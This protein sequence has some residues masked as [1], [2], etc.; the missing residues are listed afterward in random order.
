MRVT[1]IVLGLGLALASLAAYSQAWEK[2]IAPGLTYRMEVDLATPRIVHA[3][4]F[5]LGAPALKL[6]SELADGTV[7]SDNTTKGRETVTEMVTRT[8]ALAGVNGDFFPFT[9]DPLG[10]MVR[11]GQLI[12][13]PGVPPRAVFGWG[14]KDVAQGMV[15]FKGSIE[16]NGTKLEIDG[17]NEECPLNKL[18]LNTEVA[19]LAMAK[20]PCLHAIVKMDS[21]DWKPNGTYTGT[22]QSVYKDTT[23]LPIQPGNAVITAAGTKMAL[24]ETLVPGQKITIQFQTTGFDWS[25]IDQTMGGA[26]FLLR[27][28]Q[29][30]ID[31]KQQNRNDAFTLKRHP[32]TAM[33]KT[34]DG[35]I[36]LVVVDGR[37]KI[38]DGA[39]LEEMAKVMLKLG[40][41]D[42]VNLDGGGSSALNILGLTLNRPSDGKER[43]VANGALIFGPKPIA[44]IAPLKLKLPEKLVVGT[45]VTFYVVDNEG[46]P[47]PNAEVLWSSLGDAWID[48]GG[49]ARPIQRGKMDVA[50]MV[51]GQ[52]LRATLDVVDPAPPKAVKPSKGYSNKKP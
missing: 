15:D 24:I 3:L 26:P 18:T 32:R 45:G 1:R 44:Q 38:S 28:G 40:C 8:G 52:L 47:V 30:F 34:T 33:G 51:R 11:D 22:F 42:A 43:P 9:G 48:Q 46:K 37:Q 16:F 17:L 4:R 13:I 39:T 7:F 6:S 35:D 20:T 25:K 31:A 19:A 36:W 41:V 49:L 2:S 10:V 23:K 12:S 50:A 29:I 21:T 14:P 27:N 5:S